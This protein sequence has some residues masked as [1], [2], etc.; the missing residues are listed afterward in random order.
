MEWNKEKSMLSSRASNV[1]VDLSQVRVL[2]IYVAR[3]LW[4]FGSDSPNNCL[5]C[6]P[7]LMLLII[8]HIKEPPPLPYYTSHIV[9]YCRL[10][11]GD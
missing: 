7:H 8:V 1:L 4:Q 11:D 2:M 6:Q 9:L 10:I 3:S 5:T